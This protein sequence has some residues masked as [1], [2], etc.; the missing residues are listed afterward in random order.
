MSSTTTADAAP[1]PR[2]GAAT[3]V[4][5]TLAAGQFLMTLDSAV[6]NVSIATVAKDVG[7][8]V[9]GIQGA[10]TAYTLVMAALMITGAKIGAIIG[11][12]RAFAIGCVIYGIG[13]LT[14]ALAPSLPVLLLGWSLLEG[15]GAALILPAIVALVAGNFPTERRPAAY[16]LVAAA[17]AIA[18]AVGPLIGGFCTTYFSWR[19]VFAGEVVLVLVILLL[20]RRIADAPS[21]TRPKLDLVGT[22]LSAAGLGMLVFGVLRSSEWGW[23]QPKPGEPSWAGLSPTIWLIIGGLFVIW[24]FSRWE[25]F[26][27]D[28]GREPLVQPG[29]LRNRQLSGG[30]LMFFFQYLV[31]AGMFFVVPLYLSVCLGLSALE[32][33]A[34]LLPLSVTLLVAALG[35]PRFLPNISPRL[36]VRCGVFALLVGTVVLLAGLDVDSGPEVVLV[37]MLLLGLGIGA[38]ASQLGSVTVSA[39]PDDQSP[40]VG[41]VQNTMTNL[42]ASLGTALAGSVMIAAVAASFLANIQQN[43]AVPT[44]AKSQ[45]QVELAGGVQFVSDADL[46]AALAQAGVGTEGTEV[47]LEAYQDARI[48]GLRNALAILA[49]LAIVALFFTTRVPSK[50]PAAASG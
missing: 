42:G 8:T 49:A 50:Q 21:E 34:R 41:G 39:V 35:I 12:K 11:R 31:Q 3:L 5:F 48:D 14:T 16:G 28:R 33:G 45:A 26:R 9:T 13:S 30:L 2:A 4:L 24:L 15:I 1:A 29:F 7:T 6:M 25:A 36:V 43:P 47:A 37:P 23:F 40:E 44:E 18:V 27:V 38:L 19:W 32:T 10:I 22:V 17:G 46:E 20:T